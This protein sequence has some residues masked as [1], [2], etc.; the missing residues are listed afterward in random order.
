[1]R[2]KFRCPFVNCKFKDDSLLNVYNHLNNKH[3]LVVNR[4]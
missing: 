4:G 2:K 1:M 3:N